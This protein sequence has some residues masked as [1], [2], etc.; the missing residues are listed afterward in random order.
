MAL[1]SNLNADQQKAV[2]AAGGAIAIVAGPGTG[3]TK[4]IVHRIVGLIETKKAPPENILAV[5]F[6]KSAAKE[7]KQRLRDLLGGAADALWVETFHSFALR[8]LRR[9]GCPF[10]AGVEF[11]VISEEEKLKLMANITE[12]RQAHAL[13]KEISRQKQ[14]LAPGQTGPAARYQERLKAL[15]YLDFDDLLLHLNRLFEEKP[16][17]AAKYREKF[18]HVLVDEF[19]DTSFAQYQ[20]LKKINPANLCV[21]GDPDQAIY[22]FTGAEFSPFQEFSKDWASRQIINLGQNYRS[23]GTIL[24]AAKQIIERNPSDLPRELS[25]KLEAGLPIEITAYQTERQEA[26]MTVRQIENLLGGSSYFTV[27]SRWAEKEKES[28]S[29]GLGDIAILYRLNAQ[30]KPIKEALERAGLPC[31]VYGEK[32]KGEEDD[33]SVQDLEKFQ[34]DEQGIAGEKITLMTLHRVKG[35]EFSVVFIIGCEE[36]LLPCSIFEPSPPQEERRLFY[37]GVT[38]AKS[39]LFLSW[40]KK[41]TLFGKTQE[42]RPSPFLEDIGNA[43]KTIEESRAPEKRKTA[44]NQPAL[45]DLSKFEGV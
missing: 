7:M 32:N 25:A 2:L 29:Y 19:Q 9:E 43:L 11:S 23:Q 10:G 4:T 22:G 41:R 38:R 18:A 5:T 14:R 45:F 26:E 30:A 34:Q 24:E 42:N 28:Y 6:T 3:K 20:I 36:R 40:S 39:R 13:L 15:R 31:Q 33:S 37:V 8:V 27:D 17:I 12:R 21:V 1:S 16:Q 44:K 35:L